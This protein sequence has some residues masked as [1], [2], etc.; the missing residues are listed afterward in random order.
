MSEQRGTLADL[1][2]ADVVRHP[3]PGMV[4][5]RRVAF[6]PDDA[7]ITYL[8]S[9]AGTLEQQL[10]C[11]DLATGER[12]TLTGDEA[13]GDADRAF[14][15]E[16]QLRRER[17]R[18]RERGVTDYG[19]VR[20]DGDGPLVLLV[21]RGG[22]LHIRHGEGALGLLPGTEGALDAR[23][24]PDGSKVA[25]VRDDEL[26]VTATDGTGPPRQLTSGAGGGIT[27]GVAEYIAQEEMG[28][29]EGT[30]GAPTV[31]NSPTCAPTA[32]RSRSTRSSIRG[33]RCRSWR[34]TATPS[35]GSRT[36]ASSS[37]SSP[38]PVARRAGRISARTRTNIW[39]AWRGGPTMR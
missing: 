3:I 38:R 1:T 26:W 16:E 10:W 32:A 34:S 23:L 15:I 21:P 2:L 4:A 11:H 35:P 25:F 37:A 14:T 12:R 8:F 24:S 33:P 19:F 13:S 27:N 6:T 5:P 36:R 18:L 29:G 31:G 30:G 39:R 17:S 28:R 20:A 9:G 7:A 22:A